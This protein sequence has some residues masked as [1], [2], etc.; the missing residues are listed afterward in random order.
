MDADPF[1]DL[2]PHLNI[3]WQNDGYKFS[4]LSIEYHLYKAKDYLDGYFCFCFVLFINST[5]RIQLIEEMK[6]HNY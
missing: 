4:E 2:F 6:F 3:I 1:D 5:G